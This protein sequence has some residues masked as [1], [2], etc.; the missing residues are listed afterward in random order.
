[1][2]QCP[3]AGQLEQWL[4]RPADNPEFEEVAAHVDCCLR[5]QQELERLTS[6]PGKVRSEIGSQP[7]SQGLP[8][9]F[10]PRKGTVEFG[11][12]TM[13]EEGEPPGRPPYAPKS[14]PRLEHE[15]RDLLQHRLRVATVVVALVFVTFGWLVVSGAVAPV[16]TNY[17]D[18]LGRALIL[19]GFLVAAGCAIVV[20]VRRP[21]SSTTLRVVEL[22]IF[23]MGMAFAAKF[24]YAALTYGLEGSWE[25]PGHRDLFITH[26]TQINNTFW[27]FAIVCYG[28]FIPNTWRR[29]V[30]VVA[31]MVVTPLAITLVAGV[32]HEEVR[33]RLPFLVSFTALGLLV[34]AAVAVFGSFKISSLQQEAFAARQVGQYR[35]KERIGAGGMG[36]VYL[37]EHRLLKRPCAVKL[38][39]PERAS[40]PHMLRRFEREVQATARLSHFNTVE[41]YDYGH[42]EDGTFYYAM[43]YLPGM[44][45]DELVA[46]E[47]PQ[48]PARVIHFLRQLCGALREAHEAGLIHRDIK[49]SNVIVGKYGGVED[50]PKLLDFGLVRSL[51]VGNSTETKLTREGVILG[52][53][54][55]MSPEQAN[56][57]AAVDVQSDL[58]SLGAV[59]YFLLA[60]R[61]PFAGLPALQTVL[62]HLHQLPEP[63]RQHCPDVPSDLE[64]I[65]LRCLAKDPGQRFPDAASLEQALGSC[66]HAGQWTEVQARQRRQTH[67]E[68]M[69]K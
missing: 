57:V 27:A 52:T 20:W 42:A 66:V 4:Q 62:A 36:E 47:G 7:A 17:S 55:F 15:I 58:Y 43:E 12:R 34:S 51:S 5:C 18:W 67:R 63:P 10:T 25:G 9:L 49:P 40:D 61:P 50:V 3:T 21:L 6:G 30:V 64:T 1:M 44:R 53:P 31:V 11:D 45:L 54:A 22:L 19:A 32:Q 59:A 41:I 8:T 2:D 48:P 23:G 14:W 68:E 35:L 13:L 69:D 29:C 28:V 33:H 39:R 46:Q 56:G 26:I 37:A 60:G 16:Y 38:I 65:V 24:R